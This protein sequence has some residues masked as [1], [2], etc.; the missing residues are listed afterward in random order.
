MRSKS[1]PRKARWL[2]VA[3]ALL[4]LPVLADADKT[5][6]YRFSSARPD[7]LLEDTLY[8][9]LA[10]EFSNAGFS[11]TR[12]GADTLYQLGVSYEN[13]GASA[14]VSLTLR[15]TGRGDRVLA[16]VEAALPFDDGFDAAV[17][18]AVSRVLK[19]AGLSDLGGGDSAP[20][21]AGLFSSDLVPEDSQLRTTRTLRLET[22][23]AGGTSVYAGDFSQ[24][25]PYGL[26]GAFQGGALFLRRNWSVS[27]GLRASTS[28][29]FLG[30]DV[31]GGPVVIST[32]GVN[33][34]VGNGASQR[35]RLAIGFSTGA[36]VLTVG[37]GGRYLSKTDPY[38]DAGVQ[39]GFPV[40]KDLFVGADV[41][42]FMVFDPDLLILGARLGVSIAKE[43]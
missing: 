18:D 34:Q 19:E 5:V 15:E 12:E 27:L 20:N 30:E 39:F 36:A 32:A 31:E 43:F 28:R 8:Y 40:M 10:V 23:L 21:I 1:C 17:G 42:A 13:L 11:S 14:S 24:Y 41:R 29:V 38:A 35:S 3:F 16:S 7:S 25:A 33:V 4:T 22:V 9:A 6:R 26:F 2:A 37:D